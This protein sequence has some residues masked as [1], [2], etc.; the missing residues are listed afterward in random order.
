MECTP[1]LLVI[2]SGWREAIAELRRMW[3]RR[4]ARW[5]VGAE[6]LISNAAAS[7]ELP[8][9]LLVD[10]ERGK[11]ASSGFKTRSTVFYTRS[12]VV[13]VDGWARWRVSERG[14]VGEECKMWPKRE[15][16]LQITAL[17]PWSLAVDSGWWGTMAALREVEG[18][19]NAPPD[20][21]MV[22]RDVWQHREWP[23]GAELPLLL[24]MRCCGIKRLW[25][26]GNP[27]GSGD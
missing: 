11:A 14:P 27:S 1:Q 18:V 22:E 20:H 12:A 21:Q 7:S 5:A 13:I 9:L 6:W 2:N 4:E 3:R 26:S 24:D 8:S 23:G 16:G 15:E 10:R 19:R 17:G 25:E